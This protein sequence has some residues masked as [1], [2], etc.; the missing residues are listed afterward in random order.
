[1]I[2]K[3]PYFEKYNRKPERERKKIDRQIKDNRISLN[4]LPKKFKK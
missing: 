4:P 3:T 1:M 2:E